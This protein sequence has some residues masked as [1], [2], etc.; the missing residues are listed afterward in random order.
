MESFHRVVDVPV[1]KQW[2]VSLVQKMQ[3]TVGVPQIQYNDKVVN[4]PPEAGAVQYIDRSVNLRVLPALQLSLPLAPAPLSVPTPSCTDALFDWNSSSRSTCVES[5][6]NCQKPYCT[7]DGVVKG[8]VSNSLATFHGSGKRGC[9]HTGQPAATPLFIT[10]LPRSCT[11]SQLQEALTTL[12]GGGRVHARVD[13]DNQDVSR[14]TA[15][16]ETSAD[17]ADK[18]LGLDDKHLTISG[19]T[20]RVRVMKF[21]DKKKPIS[22]ELPNLSNK[23]QHEQFSVESSL[24]G[25]TSAASPIAHSSPGPPPKYRKQDPYLTMKRWSDGPQKAPSYTGPLYEDLLMSLDKADSRADVSE[26]RIAELKAN[27]VLLNLTL[28]EAA[29][30][31]KTAEMKVH[32]L[33]TNVTQ[34]TTDLAEATARAEAA[35][36]RVAMLEE[37]LQMGTQPTMTNMAAPMAYAA[38]TLSSIAAAAPE[39]SAL[40]PPPG[41]EVDSLLTS[42]STLSA[43]AA[44]SL[45]TSSLVELS[46]AVD[47]SKCEVAV[48]NLPEGL[49]KTGL[50]PSSFYGFF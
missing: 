2:H 32:E 38:P 45:S 18:I 20:R 50:C 46:P 3:S 10:N 33:E 48:W 49:H 23:S 15:R 17:V 34:L 28:T 21:R 6:K 9:A 1:V 43:V 24:F 47:D 16:V 41:L 11:S 22:L 44:G 39:I 30:Q 29:D 27:N 4:V 12:I 7:A 19:V 36:S 37:K 13:Y 5:A 42:L 31:A 25:S 35:E 40:A 8:E 26:S 14:G